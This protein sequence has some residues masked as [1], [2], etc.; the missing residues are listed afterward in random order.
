MIAVRVKKCFK[1]DLLVIALYRPPSGRINMFLSQIRSF[2]SDNYDA[3]RSDLIIIGDFNINYS[4]TKNSDVTKLKKLDKDFMITQMVKRPTRISKTTSST[5]DLLFTYT[6]FIDFTGAINLNMSDHH[7]ILCIIK[8]QREGKKPIEL[9]CISYSKVDSEA[10][11]SAISILDW[12]FVWDLKDPD[13]IWNRIYT[14]LI[15][16]LDVMC[17]YKT[18]YI[19]KLIGHSIL[20]TAS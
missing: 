9:R 19:S 18:F 12:S 11:C 5:I 3:K 13:S 10:F 7:P 14:M 1:K 8:K 6:K 2:V 15:D 16:T 20:L 4:C 17:P